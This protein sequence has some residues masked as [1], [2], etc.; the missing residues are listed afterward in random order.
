MRGC[1][2]STVSSI[3][4]CKPPSLLL[5]HVY[6]CTTGML[7]RYEYGCLG[8]RW[9]TKDEVERGKGQFICAST[10]CALTEEL[11]TYEINFSYSEEGIKKQ[12]LV[13]VRL[14]PKCVK[15]MNYRRTVLKEKI[16]STLQKGSGSKRKKEHG[17]EAQKNSK[18]KKTS[19]TDQDEEVKQKQDKATCDKDDE[20]DAVAGFLDELFL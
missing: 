7:S 16:C 17:K 2:R 9:R 11:G 8:T 6:C 14:C 20:S 18:K 1:S 13:K 12:V 3:C 5:W 19:K 15:K 4:H 10:R